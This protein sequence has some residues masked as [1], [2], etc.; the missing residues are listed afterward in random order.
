MP[1]KTIDKKIQTIIL[2]ATI[3][4]GAIFEVHAYPIAFT[5]SSGRNVIISQRP[6]RVVSLVPAITEI[7]F[8]VGGGDAVN[9]I[10]YHSSYPP[11][12]SQKKIIGGFFQPAI[13]QIR[14]LQP[15]VIFYSP[16]QRQVK[17]SFNDETCRLIH[18]HTDSIARSF[19][20]IRLLGR[21]FNQ[22]DAAEALVAKIRAELELV[23]EKIS[24]IP[25]AQHKRVV[26]L[27]GLD[28]LTTPGDDSFQNQM[29]RA[30]GGIPPLWGKN[31]KIVPVT[32]K[33]WLRFNP[34]VIYGCGGD[35][36]AVLK[37][38]DRPG[39]KD[40]EAVKKRQI[41]FFPCDLTCRAATNT[42]YFISWL[43]SKIYAQQFAEPQN[44]IRPN[45]IVAVRNLPLE[46]DYIEKASIALSRILDFPNKTLI[47]D[48]KTPLP[49][50]STLEGY[51]KG[52][53]AIGNHYASPPCW[54]IG[55]QLG[56]RQIKSR[57]YAV[58]GREPKTAS[59]LFTGADMD[60]LTVRKEM[61]KDMI[62]Y[63]LVTAGVHS[64]A[65][66]MSQD[67]GNYYEPGTINI[68]L[69]TNRKLSPRAMNRALIT[70]T[71]AKTAALGDMDIR[72]SY[73]PHNNQATGT[74]TDNIIIAQ[75]MGAA[76]D[77]TG[78]HAKMGELVARAVYRAV[79]EAVYKQNG[80][81]GRRH[82][83]QRLKDRRISLYGLVS[84]STCDCD[85][86]PNELVAGLEKVLLDPRY[87]AFVSTAFALSDDFERG[88]ISD[89]GLFDAVCYHVASEIAGRDLAVLDDLVGHELPQVTRMALNAIFNGVLHQLR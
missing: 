58:I 39:F 89:L 81:T 29:I 76:V 61:Y 27:M 7:I 70:A 8:S 15:D 14:K 37:F 55:H 18:L 3:V 48:F 24:R 64:N 16:L 74:G 5:D 87:A 20:N 25:A 77:L 21:I 32:Q 6:Q 42:G 84:T 57:V 26:R 1:S 17:A 75:G 50:V 23:N 85:I 72:S 65:V 80:I 34:Q 2:A 62:V 33:E 63:A 52:I 45:R 19:E 36:G 43:S 13:E 67:V 28:P 46:L 60:H 71:E 53:T 35:R 68:I 59:F 40:V 54:S 30:A 66:R 38:F 11:E 44:R 47:I 22:A 9:G 83:F 12:V 82:I 56:I 10:T 4:L 78:G 31:G 51:R 86:A 69:M 41:F 79:Q 49:I 88:L 73:T